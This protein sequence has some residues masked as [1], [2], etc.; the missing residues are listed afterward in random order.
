MSEFT[1]AT[2]ESFKSSLIVPGDI[3]VVSI[4]TEGCPLLSVIATQARKRLNG[5]YSTE[6]N[7]LRE[8]FWTR[9]YTYLFKEYGDYS[10][11]FEID[12]QQL[13]ADGTIEFIS[14][15]GIVKGQI[16]QNVRTGEQFRVTAVSSATVCTVTRAYGTVA[17]AQ[18]EDNDA[19]I[20]IS[21][22]TSYGT[23]GQDEVKKEAV[24]QTNYLQKI[25]T[26][27]SRDDLDD[28]SNNELDN[29]TWENAQKVADMFVFEKTIEHAKQIEKALLFSQKKWESATKSG[30][31]EG[32]IRAAIRGGNVDDISIAPTLANFTDAVKDCFKNGSS[33]M[34]YVLIGEDVEAVLTNMIELFKVQSAAQDPYM[35]EG[36]NLRFTQIMFGGGQTLRIIRHPYMTTE[37]GYGG[38]ALV[39]D[40]T[41]IKIVYGKGKDAQGKLIDGKT[42]LEFIGSESNYSIQKFDIVTYIT[43]HNANASAHALIQMV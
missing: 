41:M 6:M 26:S 24:D 19:V 13:V 39:I 27:F 8:R 10:E 31:M 40:P 30:T 42:R 17:A 7:P 15:A 29:M 43:L 5:E 20:L 36:V 14:T 11:F 21:V 18:M 33:T 25:T 23:T 28:F 16:M 9:G 35:I 32:L 4:V 37:S 2:A 34:K 12:G 38:H 22:S 1:T 3:D